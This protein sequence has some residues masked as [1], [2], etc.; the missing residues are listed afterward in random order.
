MRVLDPSSAPAAHRARPPLAALLVVALGLG[1]S[2]A[3]GGGGSSGSKG[4]PSTTT[5]PG[6]A[7]LL[8]GA[9]ASGPGPVPG[10][11]CLSLSID[12]GG[13]PTAVVELRVIDPP[14]GTALI[15][16][17]VLGSG[18][19]GTDFVGDT[20]GGPELTDDLLALGFQVI[21][22]RWELGWFTDPTGIR[23][24]SARYAVL[25]D[26]IRRNLHTTGA[27]CGVGNSGGAGEIAY[28]LTSWN[29]DNLLDVAVL[30]SGPPLSRLDYLCEQPA[31]ATWAAQCSALVP[32]GALSCGTANCEPEPTNPVCPLLP[33]TPAPGELLD[34]SI[35]HPAAELDYP[36][37]VVQMLLGA[38]D[39][40]SAVPLSLLFASAVTSAV[41][42]E[43]VPNT[44]HLLSSTQE[45]RDAIVQTLKS[46]LGLPDAAPAASPSVRVHVRWFEFE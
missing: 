30:A 35:L 19:I 21:D 23:D 36:T 17:A 5:P 25:I 39:C 2:S 41:P 37:T 38:E 26:W 8:P 3:C 7:T 33:A 12:S 15:G 13:N 24:Q 27:L 20:V 40:T 16:T 44:P 32:P 28:A 22:R 11:A 10:A 42:I 31:S 4:P 9:C 34:Q 1:L 14:A 43:F 6:T 18:G 45:G 29:G 46:A